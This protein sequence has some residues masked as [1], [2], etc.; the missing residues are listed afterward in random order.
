MYNPH[1]VWIFSLTKSRCAPAAGSLCFCTFKSRYMFYKR[2]LTSP[3]NPE[4]AVSMYSDNRSNE[5][6]SG[7]AVTL[8]LCWNPLVVLK[9]YTYS[10]GLWAPLLRALLCL[11]WVLAN[12]GES[13]E[14]QEAVWSM[15][16]RLLNGLRFFSGET[17]ETLW[18]D[19]SALTVKTF[20]LKNHHGF[21]PSASSL[22]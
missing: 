15:N 16:G 17:F 6:R 3:C 14:P 22:C 1:N 13:I 7:T 18:F 4:L 9:N 11:Q 19:T 8:P 5:P 10:T 20:S 2:E 12:H 21:P